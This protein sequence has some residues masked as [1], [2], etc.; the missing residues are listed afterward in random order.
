MAALPSLT[1]SGVVELAIA[2][3]P[4]GILAFGRAAYIFRPEAD[5]AAAMLAALCA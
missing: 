5:L 3:Q 4:G 1:R 2:A